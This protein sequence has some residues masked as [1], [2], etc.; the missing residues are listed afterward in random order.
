VDWFPFAEKAGVYVSPLL[1]AALFWM[2][3]ERNRLLTQIEQKDLKIESLAERII[4]VTAR[5]DQ[6]L[7]N[8]RRA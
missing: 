8:E 7:F 3:I 1:M 4:A 2:N 6:F 5:L